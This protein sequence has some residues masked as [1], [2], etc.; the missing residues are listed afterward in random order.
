MIIAFILIF[1]PLLST[2][3]YA[4]QLESPARND[5]APREVIWDTQVYVNQQ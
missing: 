1:T 4:Q 5:Q 2:L 3:L